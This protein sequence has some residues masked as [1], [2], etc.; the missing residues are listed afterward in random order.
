MYQNFSLD[1]CKSLESDTQTFNSMNKSSFNMMCLDTYIVF[2]GVLKVGPSD[3]F[4]IL[5]NT[6]QVFY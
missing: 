1:G 6:I 4:S 2:C 5:L 3:R